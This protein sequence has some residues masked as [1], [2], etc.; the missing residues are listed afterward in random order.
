[1]RTTE[2]MTEARLADLKREHA[3][4]EQEAADLRVFVA[5]MERKTEAARARLNALRGG[6]HRGG[7]LDAKSAQIE[8]AEA[9]LRYQAMPAAVW[10]EKPRISSDWR[11]E[12]V[13]PKRVYL[14]QSGSSRATYYSREDGM[15]DRSRYREDDGVLN[16]AACIAAL[17]ASN[18]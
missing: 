9:D 10:V 15:A 18:V 8:Q 12:K 11:V 7:L 2:P 5:D 6:Y 14:R 4:L 3:E 13:T 16:V 1:M 17:E